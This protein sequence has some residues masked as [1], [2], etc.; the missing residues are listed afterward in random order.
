[1]HSITDIRFSIEWSDSVPQEFII[2]KGRRCT[3]TCGKDKNDGDG[4]NTDIA[5]RRRPAQD[6]CVCG[7]ETA[8]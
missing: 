2:S 7:T 8:G 4:F 5:Q 3:Q 1:M 6:R